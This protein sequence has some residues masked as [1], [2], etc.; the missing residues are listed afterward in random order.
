ML[1]WNDDTGERIEVS[2]DSDGLGMV[3]I[4]FVS[5]DG[6]KASDIRLPLEHAPLLIE[7][8]QK[9][10]EYM[11]K[12]YPPMNIAICSVCGREHDV[13]KNPCPRKS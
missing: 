13:V 1:V 2:E 8:L 10:V 7:A 6:K 11:N 3:Q 12:G 4:A 9:I 5:D